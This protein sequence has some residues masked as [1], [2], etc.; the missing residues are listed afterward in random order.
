MM[1]VTVLPLVSMFATA[2]QRPGSSPGGLAWPSE[3]HWSNFAKAWDRANTLTLIRSSALI[4]VGVVPL[5]LLF[6]TMAGFALGQ[7]RVPGHNVVFTMLMLGLTVPL[8]ALVTPLYYQSR[9]LGLLNTRLAI[10]LPLIGV[11]MPFGAHWMRAHFRTVPSELADAAALDGASSWQ[12]FRHIQ[13]PLAV[14]ALTTL[15]MLQFLRAWNQFILA[16]FL[17]DD[18]DRRTMAGALGAFQGQYSTDVVLLSAGALVIMAPSVAVFIA[19]QRHFIK[20]LYEG[21]SR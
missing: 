6:A 20:A 11:S 14:P 5:S 4:V 21:I 13:V 19:L 9:S 17:V 16:V 1:I 7:L 8:E 2:L 18:P 15:A 10:I 3:F 12:A